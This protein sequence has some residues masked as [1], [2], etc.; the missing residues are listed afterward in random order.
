LGAESA[1]SQAALVT[2]EQEAAVKPRRRERPEAAWTAPPPGCGDA[3][4]EAVHTREQTTTA[5]RLVCPRPIRRQRALPGDPETPVDFVIA[6]HGSPE[7]QATQDV[8]DWPHQRGQAEALTHG[9]GR[10]R[11]PCGEP[12]ATAVWFRLGVIAY[13]LV[14]GCR[15]LARLRG[16]RR[17]GW[18]M[19]G[20]T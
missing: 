14:V 16:I 3:L 13:H 6:T 17:Q 4:A 9:I 18:A 1:S 19:T 11:V 5:F 20:A 10:Q 8:V 12:W 15:R 7:E 2:A